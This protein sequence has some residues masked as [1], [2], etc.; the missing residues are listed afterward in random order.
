MKKFEQEFEKSAKS[1]DEIIQE[2]SR[3]RLIEARNTALNDVD[4]SLEV[5]EK[6]LGIPVT[7]EFLGEKVLDL[8]SGEKTR[9]AKEAAKRGVQV[10]SLNPNLSYQ[11]HRSILKKGLEKDEKEFFT[12]GLAQELPFK[13]NV[14][15]SVLSMWAVPYY[16]EKDQEEQETTLR[17]IIR[18]LKPGG[19]AFLSPVFK[20]RVPFI[21]EAFEKIKKEKVADVKLVDGYWEDIC[22]VVIIKPKKKK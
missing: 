17:E 6:E 12:A 15:D 11:K 5:Y 16:I 18:V 4:R 22:N 3:K 1:E 7:K 14:F 13:S 10:Y 8:G 2:K 19:K 20:E 9:F 21:E